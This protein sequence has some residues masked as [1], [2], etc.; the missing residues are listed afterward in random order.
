MSNRSDDRRGRLKAPSAEQ[1]SSTLHIVG[2]ILLLAVNRRV[3]RA[4]GYPLGRIA[5]SRRRPL[6]SIDKLMIPDAVLYA[7]VSS[8]DQER[9]GFSIPAQLDL[10]RSYAADRTLCRNPKLSC[11]GVRQRL[12]LSRSRSLLQWGQNLRPV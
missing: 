5:A 10:L 7:R 12:S 3:L 1:L 2:V 8:K 4:A 9:E 11:R 6:S